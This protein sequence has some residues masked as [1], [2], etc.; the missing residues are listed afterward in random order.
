MYDGS[1]FL[2]A[3]EKELKNKFINDRLGKEE[4]FLPE[5]TVNGYTEGYTGNYIRV[6]V[7]DFYGDKKITKVRLIAPYGDGAIAEVVKD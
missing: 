6:Y 3:E 2:F 1:W 5:E 4:F 7:K